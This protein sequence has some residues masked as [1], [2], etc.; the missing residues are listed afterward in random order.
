MNNARLVAAG[1]LAVSSIGVGIVSQWEGRRLNAYLDVAGIPTICDG[2]TAGVRLGQTATHA[3]CDEKLAHEMKVV[4][5][6]LRRTI[7]V[8]ITQSMFDAYA[9]FTYNVG[10]GAWTNS[11]LLK[12]LNQ[13]RYAEACAQLLRWDK[14][15]GKQ[16]Q[17]LTNRR[18]A[19][20]RHCMKEL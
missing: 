15:G 20:Y 19:E 2:I 9:S 4:E 10:S 14:A 12:L 16:W 8:P 18:Q 17:G 11:T 6:T 3:Q 1:L 13:K 7:K 5:A